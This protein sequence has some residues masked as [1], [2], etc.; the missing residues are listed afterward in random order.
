MRYAIISDI[1]GNAEALNA[2]LNDI[3]DRHIE[4]TIC[5]GDIVGYYPDPETCID[6]IKKSASYCVAGNHDYAA[7]G[8]IDTQNFTY[9]AFAAMEWTKQNLSE[10]GKEFLRSLPL[11]VVK[12]DM[13]FTHSS[14]SNPQD[15]VYVFPDSEEAIFEAFNSLI[16]RLNFIGHT[17]WPS[18]MIQEN[19][20]IILHSDHLIKL[21]ENHYYLINVGSV[22]QPRDFDSRSCYVIYDSEKMEISIV[23]VPYDYRVTQKKIHENSLPV[24]LAERLEKGR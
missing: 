12:D 22:G 24:F 3:S 5:L 19:D 14:P 23:R 11:I 7:I 1:H 10:S 9:Y 15:W 6:L 13:F 18:I 8:K 2:V 21:S 4:Q 16:Y 20:R 17:H